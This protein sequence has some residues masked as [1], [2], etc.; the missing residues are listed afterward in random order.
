MNALTVENLCIDFA[1]P[2]GRMR[3]LDGVSLTVPFGACVAL[4]GESGSGKSTLAQ[5]VM[6]VLPGNAR[7]TGGRILFTDS[8]SAPAYDLL[9]DNGAELRRLRGARIA[10]V[11]QEPSSALSPLHTVGDQIAEVARV[12][13]RVSRK[14]AAR[15][16]IETLHACGVAD[17][18][19]VAASYPFE[20]SGGLRQRA[21][22]ASALICRPALLIA[23]EPAT[24]LDVTIQAEVL[25]LLDDLRR[26]MNLALLLIT[27]D[28]GVVANAADTVVV[29]H[30]GRVMESG[31][32]AE[33]L[34]NPRHPYLKGLI[35]AAPHLS[36]DHA[37][38]TPLREPTHDAASFVAGAAARKRE[39]GPLLEWRGVSKSFAP[40]RALWGASARGEVRAVKDV[41]LALERGECLGLVGES[42]SGKSTLLRLGLGAMKPDTG[43]VVFHDGAANPHVEDLHGPALKGYRR[44]VQLVFQD[45]FGSLNPRMTA[46]EILQEPMR[47][48][49]LGSPR[50][51]RAQ[52]ARLMG[53]VGLDERLLARYPHALSGGQRQRIG[54]ARALALDPDVLFL[55]EPVSALDVSVQAQV[56]N[57]LS[58]LKRELGLTYLLVSHDLSV[59]AHMSDR[60][61]V[62]AHGRIVELGACAEIIESPRHPYTKVLLDAFPR[63]EAHARLVAP[64]GARA[65][66]PEGWDAPFRDAFRTN[67]RLTET[68]PGHFVL[69]GL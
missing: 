14:T 45:P 67:A 40:R 15:R 26:R 64:G 44:K 63:V 23:D 49:R 9:R 34:E 48:Y 24:A 54:I 69:G 29:M 2:G 58:D 19:R 28:L 13:D 33:L 6:G 21:M 50:E 36:A 41:S 30:R 55:D 51:Q 7:V 37:R 39:K 10:M 11:F 17:A 61:A 42:G 3:A 31:N 68:A 66:E 22:I 32:C 46:L 62:M 25:A 1:V 8:E 12:H 60:I 16:A 20:L 59:V 27:H 35:G 18:E 4:V 38:L 52:A 57:L 47:A 56:L 5:A 65:A 53:L 43:D